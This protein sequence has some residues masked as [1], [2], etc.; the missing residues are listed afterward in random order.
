MS[1]VRR[2]LPDERP[3]VV[4]TVTAA[5]AEDPAWRFLMAGEYERLA[6]RFAE[7]L[8][9]LR[10][11]WGNVWVSDDLA[12]VA[13]WDSPGGGNDPPKLAEQIWARYVA[14]AGERAQ[15]RLVAYRKALA[16]VAPTEPYWY[17]GVLATR[18]ARQREGLATAAIAP[19]LG[20]A[21]GAGMT[22]CLETSTQ[23][24]RRFYERRG[25]CEPK[26]VALPAPGPPT[27]WLRRPAGISR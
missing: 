18:P 15:E 11:G 22:C 25:F 17:L 1:A 2:A 13:M 23:A 9:D 5:F 10:V 19:V 20:E 26:D 16:A 7:A 27:W 3:G 6:P 21:D 24:N 4:A 12:T 14:A 8:F